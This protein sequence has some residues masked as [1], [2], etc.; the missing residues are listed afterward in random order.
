MVAELV[1]HIHS[2][3]TLNPPPADLPPVPPKPSAKDRAIFAKRVKSRIKESGLSGRKVE[4]RINMAR[5]TLSKLYGGRIALSAE[6]LREIACALDV[7]PEVLVAGTAF[8]HLLLL[9]PSDPVSEELAEARKVIDDLRVELVGSRTQAG[10]LS[11]ELSQVRAELSQVRAELNAARQDSE[12]RSA[13]LEQAEM[14][15]QASIALLDEER[16][17]RCHL[18][19]LHDDVHAARDRLLRDLEAERQRLKSTSDA[20]GKWRSYAEERA[21]RVE[22]L[23]GQLKQTA[24][25]L[26]AQKGFTWVTGV[27]SGITGLGL[28]AAAASPSQDRLLAQYR[29]R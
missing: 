8:A 15:A 7:G 29:R 2:M 1:L 3:K 5:G 19:N 26:Q 10:S 4:D 18:Q 27:L 17:A 16:A 21:R 12:E 13:Q 22:M 20:L 28:G 14:K 6:T 9:A 11:A 23:E 24:A 25:E